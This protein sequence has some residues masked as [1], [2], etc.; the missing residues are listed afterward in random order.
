MT[1]LELLWFAFI[2]LSLSYWQQLY[3][4][5]CVVTSCCDLLSFSYLCRTDNNPTTWVST[6]GSV[7]IC[8]HFPI[9][10][11]LTT[12]TFAKFTQVKTLWFAFIFL[13]LSYWQQPALRAGFP[14]RGC[15]L[16]SFSYL[17][18]TDNNLC[19]DR[20]IHPKV[21]ICFHFPIFV[22]LTTTPSRRAS[23]RSR[24][25][26]LSFS[27]LCRTDNNRYKIISRYST[28]VICFHFPIFVVLTTTKPAARRL[29]PWVVIC[30]HFPIFVVLTTTFTPTRPASPPLWFAFIFLSLSYWQQQLY[31]DRS[32]NNCC[33]LLS[34]SYLCRTDNNHFSTLSV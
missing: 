6:T 33:D 16:L 17:C 15:D 18:R 28:V 32:M 11:V 8:F 21:V 4:R 26:L 29:L 24:C 2:F 27:Y 23:S 22:V 30:F 10:V 1:M 5:Y 31:Y 20:I 25:D 19:H 13:S 14:R 34:F 12:T 7:V 3:F 9:F